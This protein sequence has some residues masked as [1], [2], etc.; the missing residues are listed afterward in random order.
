MNSYLKKSLTLIEL[1]IA[2]SLLSV[3]TFAIF[4]IDLFSR[5]HTI[6]ADRRVRL[7]N[8]VSYV[9]DHMT[10]EISRAIGNELVNNDDT[11]VDTG[12]IGGDTAIRIYIDANGNGRRDT[13]PSAA[14]DF[15]RAYCF[16]GIAGPNPFQIRYCPRCTNVPCTTCSQP[17][18]SDILSTRISA[19]V[20]IKPGDPNP[21]T[22]NFVD[23]Q[24]IARWQPA[25]TASPD[26]PEV[27][28]RT[29]I[30]MPSVSTH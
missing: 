4:N 23:I 30:K 8:E 9:L 1:L 14:T 15:W 19:F 16:T 21:L 3:I 12:T 17:W 13:P 27:V 5:F 29:K 18:N 25:Q 6:S 26:N 20:C 7:Q 22:D 11:V 10:K 2:I 28:M 24:L